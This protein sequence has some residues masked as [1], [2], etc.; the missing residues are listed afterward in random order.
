MKSYYGK[1]LH[2]HISVTNIREWKNT[3]F[4]KNVEKPL[5]NFFFQYFSVFLFFHKLKMRT[6]GLSQQMTAIL[7]T[8]FLPIYPCTFL[9]SLGLN[10]SQSS[11]VVPIVCGGC[12]LYIEF[13][14][15]ATKIIYCLQKVLCVCFIKSFTMLF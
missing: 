7:L 8:I 5:K 2:S 6:R 3:I 15:C 4:C 12:C 11:N 13:C 1:G 10:L 9:F 14:I